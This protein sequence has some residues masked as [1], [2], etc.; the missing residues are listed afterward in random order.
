L[1]PF[2]PNAEDIF[3]K[4]KASLALFS[5]SLLEGIAVIEIDCLEED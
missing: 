1:L 4:S 2:R 5:N 3:P